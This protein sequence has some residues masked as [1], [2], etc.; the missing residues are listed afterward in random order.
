MAC[1]LKSSVRTR[2]ESSYHVIER[3]WKSFGRSSIGTDMKLTGPALFLVSVVVIATKFVG[4][5]F[6]GAEGLW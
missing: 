4:R 6:C 3:S 5:F 1:P 2:M